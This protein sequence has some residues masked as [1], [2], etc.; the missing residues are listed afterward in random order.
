MQ[1]ISGLRSDT[2]NRQYPKPARIVQFVVIRIGSGTDWSFTRAAVLISSIRPIHPPPFSAGCSC[3]CS[4]KRIT[5]R[6]SSRLAVVGLRG[7][8]VADTVSGVLTSRALEWRRRAISG[9][10]RL[11]STRRV[12]KWRWKAVTCSSV[13]ACSSACIL[14]PLPKYLDAGMQVCV[15]QTPHPHFCLRFGCN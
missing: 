7:G 1:R 8:G 12:T 5:G 15:R 14:L 13:C 6:P 3:N 4:G 10:G 2:A 9:C 11:S